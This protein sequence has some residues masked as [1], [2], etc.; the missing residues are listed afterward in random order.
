MNRRLCIALCTSVALG[1]LAMPGTA[2]AAEAPTVKDARD[3]WQQHGRLFV[4]DL[5]TDSD[6]TK[7]EAVLHPK[8]SD[9]VTATVTGFELL[10][11]SGRTGDWLTKDEVKLPAAG[12]YDIDV[13]VDEADGDHTVIEDAGTYDYTAKPVFEFTV[14]NANPNLENPVVTRTGRLGQWQ[15]VTHAVTPMAGAEVTLNYE[16]ITDKVVT[17]AEGRFAD[18]FRPGDAGHM[19][20]EG[21]VYAEYQAPGTHS[22]VGSPWTR[23]TVTKL[24]NRIVLDKSTFREKFGKAITV[25]GRAEYK[26]SNGAWK[27]ASGVPVEFD[28]PDDSFWTGEI[29]ATSGADGRFTFK[30]PMPVHNSKY[31]V[32]FARNMW[33]NDKTGG[34]KPV[35]DTI[36]VSSIADFATSL[37]KFGKLSFSGELSVAG[38]PQPHR[39][40]VVQWSRNGRDG[41]QTAKTVRVNIYGT[42]TG[43]FSTYPAGYYRA[44]YSGATGTVQGTTSKVRYTARAETRIKDFNASPEPVR[45]GGTI[46]VRG[47][48]LHRTPSWQAYGGKPVLI[49]FK[50]KGENQWY[51]MTEVKSKA[52]GT[53]TKN[54]RAP[55][56]GTWAAIHL[57]PNEKHLVSSSTE[58]YVD[59][60]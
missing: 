16:S 30:T 58:D 60:R 28:D 2:M 56:D 34:V 39:N 48:L 14:G 26:A 1:S 54:F 12:Q 5:S 21:W 35:Y 55:G 38:R 7:V 41:W 8:G 59:V 4:D 50:P 22:P 15:P 43:S 9:E 31:Q 46:T 45:K 17:D 25:G 47:T 18:S 32:K 40:V 52:N 19:G 37:D 20:S 6:V 53:F 44:V 23:V 36:G 11:G 51:L 13:V 24:P 27:P 57:Y 49:I 42:F 29:A 10:Q 33:V 3:H